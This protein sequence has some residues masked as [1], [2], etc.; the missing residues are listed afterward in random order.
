MDAV[1]IV[2]L[3]L[4]IDEIVSMAAVVLEESSSSEDLGVSGADEVLEWISETWSI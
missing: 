4:D 1:V 2:G 3:R